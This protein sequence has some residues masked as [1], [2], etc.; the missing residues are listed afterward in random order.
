MLDPTTVL[1]LGNWEAKLNF[2]SDGESK[3]LP[4]T[5][6]QSNFTKKVLCITLARTLAE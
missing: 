1:I 2:F 3:N 6:P 4:K 5:G